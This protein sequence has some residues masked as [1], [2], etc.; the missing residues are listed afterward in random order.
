M[1]YILYGERERERAMRLDGIFIKSYLSIVL[2][3]N[4]DTDIR[5][6]GEVGRKIF[7]IL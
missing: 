6:K 1:V 7:K 4:L 2:V 3:V 5:M